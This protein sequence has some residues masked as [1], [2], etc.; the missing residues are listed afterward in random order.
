M[1]A[2]R[3]M[4][5]AVDQI[6]DMIAVRHGFVTAARPVLVAPRVSAAIMIR[7]AFVG[8][9]AAYVDRMFVEVV[10]MRVME[11]TVMEIVDMVAVPDRGVAAARP[12]L[13]RMVMMDLVL[14]V[15][16]DCLLLW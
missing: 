11:V 13:V 8:I 14:A 9:A 15:G 12:V 5:V 16:H 1:A 3:V 10:V 6:V 2:V 4:Q 7:R